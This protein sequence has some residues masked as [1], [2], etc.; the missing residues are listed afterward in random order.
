MLT[1]SA[2]STPPSHQCHAAE[3]AIEYIKHQVPDALLVK[4]LPR[5]LQSD[6]NPTGDPKIAVMV[7]RTNNGRIDECIKLHELLINHITGNTP[8]PDASKPD[9][10]RQKQ[11]QSKETEK[12]DKE[13]K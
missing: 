5:L 4:C 12:K 13:S 8:M 1:L 9:L 2:C 10:K 3:K 7:I 6:I 11:Q